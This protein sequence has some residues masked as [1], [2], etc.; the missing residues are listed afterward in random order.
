MYNCKMISALS[1]ANIHHHAELHFCFLVMRTFK[2]YQF[3][4][5]QYS[6][7]CSCCV[8]ITSHWLDLY[9]EVWTC[10][11]LS[12][13]INGLC[14]LLNPAC[15]NSNFGLRL[16]TASLTV[17]SHSTFMLLFLSPPPVPNTQLY[18]DRTSLKGMEKG[19]AILSLWVTSKRLRGAWQMSGVTLSPERQKY[20]A[21]PWGTSVQFGNCS[22]C[23]FIR[24]SIGMFMG[25]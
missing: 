9:L 21:L 17:T 19:D 13:L 2:I 18:K 23:L 6:I 1:L 22:V 3:T 16:D 20:P 12:T 5:M 8:Y 10:W 25:P 11:L 15:I 14:V 7:N 4:N 24:K